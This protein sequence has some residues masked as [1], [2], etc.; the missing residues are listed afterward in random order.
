MSNAFHQ[1]N[2]DKQF[3]SPH[4]THIYDESGNLRRYMKLNLPFENCIIKVKSLIMEYEG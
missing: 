2:E 1:L 3:C 4:W